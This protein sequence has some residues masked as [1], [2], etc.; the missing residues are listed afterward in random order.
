MNNIKHSRRTSFQN[1]LIN[2]AHI[3]PL[4][5]SDSLNPSLQASPS[6]FL[7]SV[8]APIKFE[9]SSYKNLNKSVKPIINTE[10]N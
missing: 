5:F 2:L 4:N 6:M 8:P 3:P 1:N 10:R 7:L 9:S